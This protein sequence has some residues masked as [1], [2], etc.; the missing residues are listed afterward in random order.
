[1]E[2]AGREKNF[3]SRWGKR[4]RWLL[5]GGFHS[6]VVTPVS[7]RFCVGHK[8]LHNCMGERSLRRVT[9]ILVEDSNCMI[10]DD[11]FETV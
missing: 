4:R 1:M 8:T 10:E 11:E 5:G 3:S 2:P 9:G 7:E 6:L